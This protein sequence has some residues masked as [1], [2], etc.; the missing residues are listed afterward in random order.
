MIDDSYLNSGHI[1][2]WQPKQRNDRAIILKEAQLMLPKDYLSGVVKK[3]LL[4]CFLFN[5]KG[6]STL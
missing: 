3:Q 6:I 1:R 2:C 5:I 4:N